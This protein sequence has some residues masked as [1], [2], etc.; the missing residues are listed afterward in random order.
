[1]KKIILMLIAMLIGFGG[2]YFYAHTSKPD[3]HKLNLHRAVK[4]VEFEKWV[5]FN[6]KEGHFSAVF[7]KKPKTSSRDL[8]IPGSG[9]FLPYKEFICEMDNDILF[10][11]SYTTLPGAW[12]KYGNNLVL[13]GALKVIMKELGKT[14][15]VGKDSTV[16]KS[17]PALDYEH[18]TVGK[19]NQR[20]TAGTL[21]LVGNVLY[22]VEM[23]YPLELHNQVQDHLS[24]FIVNFTP[25][26]VEVIS[27]QPESSESDTPQSPQ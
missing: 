23:T 5:S 7:P 4:N 19:E 13:G 17:F 22:K 10:S 20:E 6:S 2:F 25:E 21:I 18:Y 3:Q 15:L 26:K 24:N 12:L 8:L 1:M 27:S 11:A 14:E 9:N 16:F